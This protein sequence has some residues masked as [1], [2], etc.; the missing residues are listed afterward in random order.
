MTRMRICF[1]LLG[2]AILGASVLADPL[3]DPSAWRTD[4]ASL[5]RTDRGCTLRSERQRDYRTLFPIGRMTRDVE[6]DLAKCPCLVV[7]VAEVK[8]LWALKVRQRGY[9][10]YASNKTGAFHYDLR[11]H[12]GESGS[13]KVKLSVEALGDLAEV[14]VSRLAFLAETPPAAQAGKERTS[15][16]VTPDVTLDGLRRN[17]RHPFVALS[18]EEIERI[19]S[20]G[21]VF[22]EWL[23]GC[24]R[25]ADGALTQTVEVPDDPCLYVMEYN[26]PEHGVPLTWREKSPTEHLCPMG[27]HIVTGEKFDQQWRIE[28]TNRCHRQNQTALGQLGMAYAFC[29]DERYAT[30]AREILIGYT[31]KFPNYPYHSGRGELTPEGVGMRLSHQPL[32]EAG[33]L[34]DISRGY[35]L[36]ASSPCF[37]EA[38]HR[39]V[40]DLLA[41]DVKVSLHSDEGLSNRQAHHNLAVVSV[42]LILGDEFLIRRALGSLRYQLKYAVLGDGL[43]WECSPGYHFYAIRTLREV[44]ETFQRVGISAT[45]D[46]KLRAAYDAPLKFLWPDGTFPAVN[47]SHLTTKLPPSDYEMLYHLYRDPIYAGIL[48]R[49]G[50]RR[51]RSLDF[52]LHGDD[53][54]ADAPLPEHSWNFFHAGMTILKSPSGEGDLSA[55]MD[56]GQA[57]AGH[58]HADKLNLILFAD[59]KLLVPDIGTRSYFSPVYRF[60]DRQTLSHNTVV[61]DEHSQR[62]ER[63]RMALCDT[64][65]P[66]QAMQATANDAYPCLNQTR[67]CFVTP[68]YVVDLFRLAEDATDI[69]L[70]PSPNNNIAFWTKEPSGSSTPESLRRDLARFERSRDAHSGSYSAMI[71]QSEG[72]PAAWVSDIRR[73]TGPNCEYRRGIIPV[74][75]GKEHRLSA[76]VKTDRATGKTAVSARWLDKNGRE[77]GAFS[78]KSVQGTTA[79]TELAAAAVA[80]PMAECVQVSCLSHDN[81]GAAWFDD[82]AMVQVGDP[83]AK[84]IL[85]PNFDF[86]AVSVPHK[87]VDYV[88]HGSG[89]LSCAVASAPATDALGENTDD[90]TQDG[91]NSYRFFKNRKAGETHEA[92]QAQWRDGATG[93]VLHMAGGVATRVLTGDGQG[94]EATVLPMLM[95]RR[96]EPNT[97]FAAVLEPFRD[98]P[99]LRSVSLLTAKGK[100]DIEACGLAVDTP[101]GRES[102]AA[103][104]SPGEK[105]FP[106]L[107]LD[108]AIGSLAVGADGKDLRWMYLMDGRRFACAHGAIASPG[109]Y[110]VTIR[111]CDDAAKTVTVAEALPPGNVL[112]GA[113][114]AL[115]P[116]YNE[117]YT[118]AKIEA[119]G[120][121]SLVHLYGLPNL[122]F[123]PGMAARIPA[124]ASVRR[125]RRDLFELRASAPAEIRLSRPGPP[126][127]VAFR[128]DSGRTGDLTPRYDNGQAVLDAPV[129]RRML[130]AFDPPKGVGLTDGAPPAI[131]T[132]LIDDSQAGPAS[133][134][135]VPF[136]PRSVT[137]TLCDE[138]GF[139]GGGREVKLNG[140]PP[141][142]QEVSFRTL[143]EDGR[144]AQIEIRPDNAPVESLSVTIEDGSPL[145]NRLAFRLATAPSVVVV[146]VKGA[147]GGRAAK[148]LEPE[149]RLAGEVD[150]PKGD[151]EVNLISRAPNDGANSVWLELDG[152]RMEDAIH[153]R[154]DG[155]GDSSRSHDLRPGR[156]RL[157]IPRDGKHDVV[158]TLR[159]SPGPELDRLQFLQEGKVVK[160]LECEDMLVRRAAGS[161]IPA[162]RT[163]PAPSRP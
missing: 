14:T 155:F 21:K 77:V 109:A 13:T 124:V 96:T 76:W 117:C 134:V 119:Q 67:T 121:G 51:R 163:A 150:L 99:A 111:E 102:F 157:R 1:G 47:D 131:E 53:L 151:Y 158:I 129:T 66:V 41:E 89:E 22:E 61:V 44:A 83:T 24:R 141:A 104:F 149:A 130:V 12:L 78:T 126:G 2:A 29:G 20:K 101:D 56:Y 152:Q 38:D 39:A 15:R 26:C 88:L 132:L 123:R 32:S 95:A 17:L 81:A 31:E 9:L 27:N 136:L 113:L 145:R 72:L 146:A 18:H 143:G 82:I 118:I 52:L 6:V 54:D 161:A 49:L 154:T 30:R 59:G 116:P 140:R 115:E 58:G 87:A 73:L 90:P 153:I 63:G 70:N 33:W 147:G 36:V 48:K 64:G 160:E 128:D 86:E 55:V 135:V 28:R 92:W 50:D 125:L 16:Y 142:A 68:R 103:S 159:E 75:P 120:G 23:A 107:T 71:A 45:S 25:S 93:L 42:G 7:D 94:P 91:Q 110:R 74:T 79:W 62:H 97:V 138:S 65:S 127:R 144:R 43:W 114:F 80:P 40:R 8:G 84:N 105:E 106:H 98:K 10:Q 5:S 3:D 100:P 11:S 137:L 156:C 112:E 57:V 69:K 85:A 108:G 139:D 19:K 34:A 148:L 122:S 60:W 46:P 162:G 37:S 133:E 35:D 4:G